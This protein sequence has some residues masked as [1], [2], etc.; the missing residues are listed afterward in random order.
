MSV[1]M[2]RRLF[3]ML[4]SALNDFKED[5]EIHRFYYIDGFRAEFSREKS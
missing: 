4:P 2:K 1:K 3:M 5:N